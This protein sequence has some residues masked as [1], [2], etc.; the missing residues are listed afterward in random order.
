MDRERPQ[1]VTMNLKIDCSKKSGPKKEVINVDM[2]VRD[3]RGH[4]S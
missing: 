2:K 3:K 4:E 1:S